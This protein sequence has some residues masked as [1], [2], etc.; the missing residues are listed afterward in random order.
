MQVEANRQRQLLCY[1]ARV[2]PMILIMQRTKLSEIHGCV[3]HADG[4][5]V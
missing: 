2:G 3:V 1:L 5:A 4:S